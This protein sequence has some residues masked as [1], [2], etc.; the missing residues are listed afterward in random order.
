MVN[1]LTGGILEE[2][3]LANVVGVLRVLIFVVCVS[4]KEG[5]VTD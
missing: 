5:G 3:R 1:L 4:I 2:D